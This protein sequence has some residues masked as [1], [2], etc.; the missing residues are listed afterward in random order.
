[1]NHWLFV[2]LRGPFWVQFL[3]AAGLIW[4]GYTFQTSTLR[5]DALEAAL[6]EQAA[7]ATIPITDMT[8]DYD[9]RT[10]TEVAVT[11]QVALERTTR[12]VRKTNFIT[13]SED[14]LFVLMDANATIFDDV[15]YGAIVVD[16]DDADRVTDWLAE[17]VTSMG[18]EGPVLTV[19]GLLSGSIR[20]GMVDDALKD[21]G[22]VK[23]PDFFYVMPHFDGRVAALTPQPY[24][25][26][27]AGA[28]VYAIAAFFALLGIFKL[29]RSR[30]APDMVQAPLRAEHAYTHQTG[31]QIADRLI[32][33]DIA[34]ARIE[35]AMAH[36]LI[37]PGGAAPSQRAEEMFVV[38]TPVYSPPTPLVA[39]PAIKTRPPRGEGIGL[40]LR[41]VLTPTFVAYVGFAVLMIVILAVMADEHGNPFGAQ[42]FG[43]QGDVA[44]QV[45]PWLVGLV[46]AI[47]LLKGF[48]WVPQTSMRKEIY[49]PYLRLA[50]RER[51][52]D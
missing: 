7:P 11:A 38:P 31:Q 26:L 32:A 49:D 43:D 44:G 3:C 9:H 35:A 19:T 16:A 50:E 6:L 22:M 10:A 30:R 8:A 52:D 45:L 24:A 23:S 21:R 2:L 27:I 5:R 34:R 25:G 51:A 17:N 13:T 18:G 41:G 20:D 46:V 37:A 42:T 36:P 15:A 39:D 1:M 48:L 12:L 33:E 40:M 47:V 28:W 4:L 14:M 29:G